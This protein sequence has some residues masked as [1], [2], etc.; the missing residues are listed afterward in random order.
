M[1]DWNWLDW[2]L[3]AILI[4]SVGRA[5]MTGLVRAVCGLLGYF[6]GFKLASQYYADLG[7]RIR[8]RGFV[9]TDSVA[10]IIAFVLIVVVMVIIFELLGRSMKAKLHVIGADL[11][12]RIFGSAFG[13]VRACMVGIGILM[14]ISSF[15]PKADVVAKSVLTPYL[16]KVAD[17]M[18][19]LIPAYIQQ[20]IL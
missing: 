11:T 15:A 12:D 1:A 3:A 14:S 8:E 20:K 18:S 17:N 4:F 19:F 6:A 16:M 9:T 7:D 5:F 2:L 13:F 10:Q